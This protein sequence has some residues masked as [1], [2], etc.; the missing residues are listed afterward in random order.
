MDCN[1]QFNT[2]MSTIKAYRSYDSV[3]KIGSVQNKTN[4]ELNCSPGPLKV[5][6]YYSSNGD[7]ST[8]VYRFCLR[9]NSTTRSLYKQYIADSSTAYIFT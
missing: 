6:Y 8:F 4:D 9:K 5:Q 2:K 7:A 1:D 3:I